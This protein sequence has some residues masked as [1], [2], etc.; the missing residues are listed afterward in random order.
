MLIDLGERYDPLA[1]AVVL[2]NCVAQAG[3]AAFLDGA[4]G[5]L[6]SRKAVGDFLKVADQWAAAVSAPADVEFVLAM[7]RMKLS[8]HE[9][10]SPFFLGQAHPIN[11]SELAVCPK[12]SQILCK[13]CRPFLGQLNKIAFVNRAKPHVPVDV[14]NY[15][16]SVHWY[17]CGDTPQFCRTE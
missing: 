9:A 13:R 8:V 15:P 1:Q 2:G 4:P 5:W 11:T 10:T 6:M 14:E 12:V 17:M 7:Q 16:A 3:G